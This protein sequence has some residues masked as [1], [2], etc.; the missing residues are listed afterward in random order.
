MLWGAVHDLEACL[1]VMS[2]LYLDKFANTASYGP[3]AKHEFFNCLQN[4]PES[5]G[6][7]PAGT[8][9]SRLS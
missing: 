8:V 4:L 3:M 9:N 7:L 2:L 5:A 1:M 6:C